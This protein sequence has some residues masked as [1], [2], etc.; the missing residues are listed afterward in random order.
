MET[1]LFIVFV[2]LLFARLRITDWIIA[3]FFGENFGNYIFIILCS[4]AVDFARLRTSV[5]G[6][7]AIVVSQNDKKAFKSDG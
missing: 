4:L 6:Y 1:I 2:E 5:L 3:Q 7:L